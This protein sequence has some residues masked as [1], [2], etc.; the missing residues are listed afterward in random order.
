LRGLW[1]Y[2]HVRA[3]HQTAHALGEQLLI[4][5]QQSQD[6]AMQIIAHRALGAT[7]FYLGMVAS[8]YTHYT[9]GVALYD[10]GIHLRRDTVIPQWFQ[11]SKAAA[12]SNGHTMHF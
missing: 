9:Q 1:N 8:A 4:L 10:P 6:S 7:L 2:Y 5:A 12:A 11:G 3:E